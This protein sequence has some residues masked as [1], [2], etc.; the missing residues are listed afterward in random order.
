MRNLKMFLVF[1][2]V[3][4]RGLVAVS[5][6]NEGQ[7][8]EMPS[9]GHWD[10]GINMGGY[11]A[12]DRTAKYYNGSSQNE[13]KISYVFGNEYWYNDI[14]N[15]L[16][17]TDTVFVREL[18]LDMSYQAAFQIGLFF[19]RTFDN[20]FG[21]TLQFDYS[22]LH[23]NDVY[24]VEVDP[25]TILTEPDI[26]PYAI[27]GVENRINIDILLSRYFKTQKPQY[28][29][30]AEVGLNINS[31]TVLENKIA[32]GDLEYSLIDVY[33][34]GGY[35]PNSGQNTYEVYQGGLGYGMSLAGGMRFRFNSQVSID[36]GIRVYFQSVNLEGYQDLNPAF[37]FFIRLNLSD[38]FSATE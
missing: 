10:L 34:T 23:A 6:T 29:P 33:L 15:H 11:W 24:T 21:L 2:L 8:E 37:S 25:Y 1:I 7:F 17:A 28:M 9:F 35:V 16:N 13:N 27:W 19:R 5:Q 3:S 32:V 36:P 12:S 14:K 20:Y 4:A 30:F 31:T 26:R 22:K 38:Y 18:P